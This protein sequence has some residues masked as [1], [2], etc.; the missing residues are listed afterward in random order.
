MSSGMGTMIDG[1]FVRMP[2]S[3]V[4]EDVYHHR[5]ITSRRIFSVELWILQWQILEIY[6]IH[7][8]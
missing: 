6:G 2:I 8:N 7:R 4:G 5:L 3:R 1:I